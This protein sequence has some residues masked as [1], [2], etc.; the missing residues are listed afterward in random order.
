MSPAALLVLRSNFAHLSTL[1]SNRRSRHSSP[2]P[3]KLKLCSL[4]TTTKRQH[5][6]IPASYL[7]AR[8]LH[9]AVAT[10]ISNHQSP[11]TL[12]NAHIVSPS[13]LFPARPSHQDPETSDRAAINAPTAKITRQVSPSCLPPTG[14][15]LYSPIHAFKHCLDVPALPCHA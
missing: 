12:P 11:V 13:R 14:D 1:R 7:A 10:A 6:L 3:G 8:S 5:G 15:R 2:I 9:Q 4:V